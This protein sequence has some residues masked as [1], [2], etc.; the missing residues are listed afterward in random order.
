VATFFCHDRQE[1]E[2]A[3]AVLLTGVAGSVGAY[4]EQRRAEE[5][6]LELATTTDAYIALVGHELRTPLT[7]IASYA[8]LIAESGDDTRVGEVRDLLEVVLRNTATMRCL[9]E[10]L[11]DLAALESGHA[12]VELAPLD[13]AGIVRDAVAAA[14]PAADRRR[15]AI[16]ADLPDPVPVMGDAGR[17]RQVLDQLLDNGIKYTPEGGAPISVTLGTG[18]AGHT[19]VL[20]ITDGG[21]GIPAG[22]E[23][24]LLR[25]LYRA[26]NARHTGIP[27]AGLG[28]ATSRVILELHHGTVELTRATALTAGGAAPAGTVVTVRLP[29]A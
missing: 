17:L 2:P 18:G 6:A 24:Q 29:V 14:R 23:P 9:V 8:E 11:L 15:L 12:P 21:I 27:G 13:L 3:L 28:L 1:P 26:G 7:S 19:A 5:L 25:R 4:L 22:E 16:H 10:R 20:S